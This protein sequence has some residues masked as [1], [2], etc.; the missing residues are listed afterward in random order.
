MHHFPLGQVNL[1]Q[2]IAVQAAKF[3]PARKDLTVT[4]S[5]RFRLLVPRTI[6]EEMIAHA[7]AELPNECCGLLAGRRP[8]LAVGSAE[9]VVEHR[10]ELINKLKSATEYESE[11]ASMIAA[12]KDMRLRGLEIV[13]IYH[14][15]PSSA[16]VPSKKDLERNFY[17]DSVIHFIVSLAGATPE[18]RGWWLLDAQSEPADEYVAVG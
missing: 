13:G 14:S 11:D 7:Q 12:A 5:G 17:G 18:L 16:P 2:K 6:H 10:Y 4:S 15:H 1:H 8:S 9:I 3:H